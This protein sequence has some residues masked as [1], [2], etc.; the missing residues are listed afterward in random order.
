M[1][2]ALYGYFY[3]KAQ[4]IRHLAK[5]RTAIA[6]QYFLF[7]IPIIFAQ[8]YHFIYLVADTEFICAFCIYSFCAISL[9]VGSY[10]SLPV[11]KKF[12]QKL[13]DF[14]IEE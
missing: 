10:E 8:S 7:L 11:V 1:Y 12:F 9:W 4:T 6:L 14:E 2:L 3:A 5:N 13:W